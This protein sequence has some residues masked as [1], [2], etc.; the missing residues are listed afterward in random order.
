MKNNL[1]FLV[2]FTL[3]V[4]QE[5][6]RIAFQ[7]NEFEKISWWSEK[8]NN[9]IKSNDSYFSI[10]YKKQFNSYNLFSTTYFNNNELIIGESFIDIK[11]SKN[12]NLKLGRYYR[13][14]SKYLSDDISSGSML[15][16]INALPMPKVG[17][18]GKFSP[19]SNS[20]L[21]FDYGIS[22]AI[23]D[24]N[25][26]YKKAPFVHEKFIYLK[27]KHRLEFGIGLVHEA[28]W[29][30]ATYSNGKFPNKF[31]D[32]L[33]I[34]ISAD[35]KLQDGQ[36]HSNALGNHLG[37]WDFYII[38]NSKNNSLKVYYQHFFEDTSGLRF[39]NRIDGLWGFE[40]ID[41]VSKTNYLIEYLNTTNQDR[42]PPYVNDAYYNHFEYSLGWSYS[43]KV[44]GNPFINNL[45]PNPLEV[46][47]LGMKTFKE[48]K[49]QLKMLLSR[50][51]DVR[52]DIKYSVNVG[53]KFDKIFLQIFLNGEKEKNL[54][55]KLIYDI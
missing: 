39:A 3:V 14:F 25:S 23:L 35:D 43:G 22:H 46:I 21:R 27:R 18:M 9:G 37:I 34:I 29:A 19:K 16:S 7:V 44:I 48:D 20:K 33:K 50:R 36:P 49:L 38:K 53:R 26:I 41:Q 28:I 45:N 5:N 6:N 12:Y 4:G 52:D 15:I 11:I 47:H 30:G 1:I 2:F 13:D 42:D 10:F 24:S 55:F 40:F 17:L 51:I 8:N 32:F 54:G 31:N